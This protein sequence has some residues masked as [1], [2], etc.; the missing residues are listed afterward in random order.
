MIHQQRIS[1]Q[2]INTI[3]VDAPY[4]CRHCGFRTNGEELL[5]FHMRDWDDIHKNLKITKRN[6]SS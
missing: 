2:M 1:D 4:M 5:K 3:I 6:S